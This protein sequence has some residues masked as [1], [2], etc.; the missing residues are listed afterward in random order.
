MFAK[1]IV[2]TTAWVVLAAT[3]LASEAQART[4]SKWVRNT[5]TSWT[6]G[7][8][9]DDFR[10]G[11][12]PTEKEPPFIK[13]GHLGTGDSDGPWLEWVTKISDL[14]S[15]VW[16]EAGMV[17]VDGIVYVSGAATNSFLALDAR[18]GLPIWR[19]SPDGRTDGATSAYPGSNAPVVKNGVA[20]VTF[21]TGWMYALNAKTGKKIWSYQAK[22]G[23]AVPLCANPPPGING[24]S[25][26]CAPDAASPKG[27]CS[28]GTDQ[29]DPIDPG[30]TYTKI[31]GATAFCDNK[32]FFMTLGGWA[33][34]LDARTGRLLWKKYADAPDFPGELTWWEYPVGGALSVNNKSAGMSTRRFEAVPGLACLNGEVQVA[35]SDGHVRFLDPRNGKNSIQGGRVGPEY[36]RTDDFHGAG[37]PAVNVVDACQAA[38]WNCDIAVGLALPPLGAQGGGDYIVTTLD[39]RIIRLRRTD[40]ARLWTRV[41]DSPLPLELNG[42]FLPLSL[43]HGEVGFLT[44]AVVG[45]P[46]ALDP[47]I[48]HGG[49]DPILYAPD[50]DGRLYV[51]ALNRQAD[52]SS[53]CKR[54]K[55]KGDGF[56]PCLLDRIGVQANTQPQT[57]YTRRGFGG[58]WDYNQIALS[59]T[60]LGGDVLYI[61]TWDNKI[62]GFD[63]R[64]VRTGTVPR[65]VWE[66]QINWD[67]SFQYPP[68][69]QTYPKPFADIDNKI[70]SSPALLG[71]HL[72][73]AANDGRVY[74]FNLMHKVKTV[75]N[76][77]ILGSGLVPF[78]PQWKQALGS[79]DRVWTPADWYKNQVPP[80]GYRLP[81]SAGVAGAGSLVLANLVLLWWFARRE[82]FEIE[83][84]Q[85]S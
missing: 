58:P 21:S 19:F 56:A 50:Q 4:L 52:S 31:H 40:H 3:L 51:L 70:F 14:P 67:S 26:R 46:M 47:D 69:G 27:Y 24:P 83:V 16:P 79:F 39:G 60:V 17:V 41:Y 48:A 62:T 54:P 84:S 64:N 18:T 7:G 35:G 59:G 76:L 66:Y 30:V 25:N 22:D 74:A 49:K 32:V 72:Y 42:N 61:P 43:S 71:G 23:C 29:T 37:T 15:G 38:G 36:D 13:T 44:Q 82:D 45:G 77:V 9:G 73:F 57:P 55:D 20:Y 1:L 81:K 6:V 33:Y 8:G 10:T 85:T 80:A 68:F 78:L 12:N 75:K 2:A 53:L 65:K 63:V 34:G 28:K 5:A 11:F